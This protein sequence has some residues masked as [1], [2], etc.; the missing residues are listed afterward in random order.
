[1]MRKNKNY[2]HYCPYC[3]KETIDAVLTTT[4]ETVHLITFQS[5]TSSRLIARVCLECGY[6]TLQAKDPR[7]LA[8]EDIS[9]DELP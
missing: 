8:F 4:L 1:M 6:T 2:F 7:V 5:L 9:E 3:G